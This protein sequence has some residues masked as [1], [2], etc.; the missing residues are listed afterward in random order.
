MGTVVACVK[1]R[2]ERFLRQAVANKLV[3]LGYSEKAAL[4]IL[5]KCKFYRTDEVALQYP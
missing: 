3:S 1:V 2:R 5:S 4:Q